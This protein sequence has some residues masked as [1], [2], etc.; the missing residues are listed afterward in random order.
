MNTPVPD[1]PEAGLL[2]ATA[3]YL[4]TNYAKSGCP[5]L[6]RHIM[7]QLELLERHPDPGVPPALRDIGRKLIFEWQRIGAE[8]A[9]AL[10]E[11][12]AEPGQVKA[13]PRMH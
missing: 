8:R 13:A 2:L 12:H 5:M 6:C 7:R 3:L 4:A 10:Q 11:A 1:L 9:F